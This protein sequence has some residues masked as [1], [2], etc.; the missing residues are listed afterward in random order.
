MAEANF[1]AGQIDQARVYAGELDRN[2][3]NYPP[4][5]LLQAQIDLTQGDAK[6]ALQ[7]SSQLLDLIAKATPGPRHLAANAGRSAR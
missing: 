4:A 5:K 7:A 2:Y 3:P 6:G 1:R